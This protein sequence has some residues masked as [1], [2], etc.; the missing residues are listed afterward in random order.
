MAGHDNDTT[1]STELA[2]LKEVYFKALRSNDQG[3]VLSMLGNGFDPTVGDQRPEN[4]AAY[5]AS[6]FPF[7]GRRVLRA[8]KM[9]PDF[10]DQFM[11]A[12]LI[13][14]KSIFDPERWD[15]LLDRIEKSNFI[16]IYSASEKESVFCNLAWK[17]ASG[18]LD[19]ERTMRSFDYRPNDALPTGDTTVFG[20]I[21][22][23]G[24]H[25]AQFV[26]VFEKLLN[27][28]AD[29]YHAP[30]GGQSAIEIAKSESENYCALLES[31]LLRR[32]MLGIPHLDALPSN[33]MNL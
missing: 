17:I 19:A 8:V 25:H 31:V 2:P 3:K 27:A 9:A 1:L 5:S 7:T 6:V 11:A 10:S 28:G 32:S 33:A 18:T 20:K 30:L 24:W 26:T 14:S 21:V 13:Y 12:F 4:F 22:A 16:N 29:P 15:W 23:C